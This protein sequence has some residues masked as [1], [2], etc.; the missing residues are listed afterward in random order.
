MPV[1]FSI[2]TYALFNACSKYMYMYTEIFTELHH[3]R[4]YGGASI[5]KNAE[6]FSEIHYASML[7]FSACMGLEFSVCLVFNYRFPT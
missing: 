7:S 1:I 3:A 2:M 6:Y 4:F 5:I